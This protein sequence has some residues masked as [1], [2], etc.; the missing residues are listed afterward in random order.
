MKMKEQ[1]K[2]RLNIGAGFGPETLSAAC[3][4]SGCDLET[5]KVLKFA[6]TEKSVA[7]FLYISRTRQIFS[8]TSHSERTSTH[9]L[10]FPNPSHCGHFINLRHG[11]RQSA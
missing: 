10:S 8:L 1:G 6:D 2:V 9:D 4:C 5:Q 3:G 7:S 11:S